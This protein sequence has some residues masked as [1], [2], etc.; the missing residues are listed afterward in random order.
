MKV[1]IV[2]SEGREYL[3]LITKDENESDILRYLFNHVKDTD[4]LS[5]RLEY[6]SPGGE[7]IFTIIIKEFV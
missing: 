1:K 4:R 3:S 2:K 6:D 5:H 7:T